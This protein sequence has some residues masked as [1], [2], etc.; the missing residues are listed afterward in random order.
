MGIAWATK[1]IGIYA[2]AGLAILFFW[3]LISR[4]REHLEAMKHEADEFETG[5]ERAAVAAARDDFWKNTAITLG[6]CVAFFLAIPAGIYFLSYY[7]QLTPDGKFTIKDILE[8]QKTMYNYHKG[9]T[10][11]DHYFRSP[12]YE[13]PVIAWPMWFY[14]GKSYMP[15][16]VISSISCMG[17]PAVW[18]TGLVA[19][20]WTIV[21]AAWKRRAS[22]VSV[23]LIIGFFS[24]YLPWTLVPRSMFIYHYFASV[25]FIIIATA[26]LFGRLE[27]KNPRAFRWWAIALI[28]AA[29]ILFVMFYPLESGTPVALSYAKH[30]RWFD[31]YNY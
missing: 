29:L 4:F 12:W 23:I 13:W 20:V 15:D 31:W 19:M 9:L 25:P 18:W 11:D 5:E 26:F 10:N 28:A 27:K 16:G 7:W 22:V 8:L 1:W 30:L 2:S 21:E 17:N 14:D 24:Q 6:V 3:S